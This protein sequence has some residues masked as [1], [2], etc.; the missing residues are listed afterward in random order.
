MAI[1]IGEAV[2]LNNPESETVT[3]DDRQQMM[4]VIGGVVVQD[5]GHIEAGDKIAWTLQFRNSEWEK[6]RGYWNRREPVLVED[7]AG[8]AFYARIVVKSYSRIAGFERQAVE[9]NIELWRV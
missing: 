3:P 4:E 6:V 5:Y 8:E 2:S 9:A 1:R 7:A